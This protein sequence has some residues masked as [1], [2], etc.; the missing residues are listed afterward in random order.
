[1]ACTDDGNACT[2]D[3][4][5][6]GSCGHPDN[7][8]FCLEDGNA[9]TTD[10]CSGGACIHPANSQ[11]CADDGNA[12]TTDQCS[13]GECGHLNNGAACADDGN[14]CTNDLCV[15]GACGHLNNG[16][17]CAEDGN[18]CTADVCVGGAC[19]HTPQGV[20]CTDGSLCTYGDFCSGGACTAKI[21]NCDDSNAC[22][23][24][25]C[26]P[27]VGC[28]HPPTAGGSCNDGNDC[29]QKD[30][31]TAGVCAG[32]VTPVGS[33]CTNGSCNSG[34]C[35]PC[36]HG[37]VSVS[38][39]GMSVCA[40]DYPAWGSR[41]IGTLGV[42][43]DNGDGTVSDSQTGLM[44]QKGA[45]STTYTWAAARDYCDGLSLGNK[46]DW[47]LPTMA[48]LVSIVDYGNSPALSASWFGA[49]SVVWSAIPMQTEPTAWYV[50]FGDGQYCRTSQESLESVRCVRGGMPAGAALAERFVVTDTD[51]V[52]DKATGLSW[53]QASPD[54]PG[55]GCYG[56]I[57][58]WPDAQ[59][60]CNTLSLSGT[61]WRLPN[62]RELADL[63]DRSNTVSW[64]DNAAFPGSPAYFF[65]TSEKF[66]ETPIY[67]F[68]VDF[69]SGCSSNFYYDW[70]YRVRCVRCTTDR[71]GA[72]ACLQG[73]G[74][75]C[76]DGNPCT[77]GDVCG[78]NGCAGQLKACDD[79]DACTLDACSGSAGAVCTHKQLPAPCD[80]A[81][82]CTVGDFCSGGSC[83][84]G[85]FALPC[86]D[87]LACTTDSCDPAVGCKFIS[88]CPAGQTCEVGLCTSK[89]SFDY[90][91]AMQNLV[92]PPGTTKISV[93][94]WGAGGGSDAVG[95]VGGAGGYADGTLDVTPGEVLSI[96]VGGAGGACSAGVGTGGFGGGGDGGAGSL[97]ACGG[98]GRSEV[99]GV[100]GTITAGGGGGSGRGGAKNGG[101]G[102]GALGQ[103][104][105]P[106]G[107]ACYGNGTGGIGGSGGGSGTG[108]AAGTGC[109]GGLGTGSGSAGSATTG[110]KGG[111][112]TRAGG[113]GG[114]GWGGGGGGGSSASWSAGAGGGGGGRTTAGGTTLT[115]D[116]ATPPMASSPYR[117]TA[118]EPD[119]P[120]KVVLI[121]Q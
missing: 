103:V 22:T 98:G 43:V 113:G 107:S 52:L 100:A 54:A 31:C 61:G 12:C 47:R 108:G 29:T 14:A 55:G 26:A 65:W 92:V 87:G 115:G 93:I 30:T 120:G 101:A 67:Y 20:P 83:T 82:A 89:Q 73:P 94:M 19:G 105:L 112:G 77:E 84:A 51:I 37:L 18:P 110:G 16:A 68:R 72:G 79:G 40:F 15:A 75:A 13:G 111:D 1:M 114:G 119:K 106:T 63:V 90:T 53:Q 3:L 32:T 88:N 5:S 46:S 36:A 99:V 109:A 56:G 44:W 78:V 42:Y 4:C 116:T 59:N 85:P 117:G 86:N 7:S 11:P 91:G 62:T 41:P 8:L 57:C 39:D 33:Y 118:G 24:D 50:E 49:A 23:L 96:L 9:C 38:V 74:P 6:G 104:G 76:D 80:D 81:N 71:C 48:E 95:Y 35:T 34:V 102:G 17:A 97:G 45:T 21:V 69:S 70:N 121:L 64:I 28:L 2:S 10:I 25:S 60:Y 66:H 27:A 58:K